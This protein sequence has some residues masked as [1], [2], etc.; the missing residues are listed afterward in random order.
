MEVINKSDPVLVAKAARVLKNNG[1]LIIPTVRWYMFCC[2]AT[3]RVGLEEIFRAKNRDINKPPLFLVPNEQTARDLF[4]IGKGTDKLISNFWP[5][6]IAMYLDWSSQENAD[7]FCLD[8]KEFALVSLFSKI[9]GNIVAA[10]SAPV[11]STTVNVSNFDSSIDMGPAI[12]INEVSEFIR[13]TNIK[14]D[15]V[16][17]GGVCPAFNHTTIM[18]C[19]S[20][21]QTL[22]QIVREGYVHKRAINLA[23]GITNGGKNNGN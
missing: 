12:S 15:L 1:I 18:D 23:L 22:P 9:F 16:V 2:G 6:E 11:L 19:R 14:V 8:N 4:V 20:D 5:G 13:E 21:E 10:Y 17:D 3:N 7:K